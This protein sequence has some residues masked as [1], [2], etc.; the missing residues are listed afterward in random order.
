LAYCT[1][2]GLDPTRVL[3]LGDGPND[4]ELLTGAA[5]RLVPA[6]AH[7]A[8]L[9]LATEVIPAATEGGWAAVLDHV[10]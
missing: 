8:A 7:P 2:H 10:A 6:V 1:Q 4:V 5:V 3:A 9:D